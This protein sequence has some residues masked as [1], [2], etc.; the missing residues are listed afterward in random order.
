MSKKIHA[1]QCP[2]CSSTEQSE[3]KE[4]HYRCG[5]CGTEY[6]VENGST[7]IKHYHYYEPAPPERVS[8]VGAKQWAYAIFGCIAVTAGLIALPI[9]GKS[10]S[11]SPQSRTASDIT[12]DSEGR[13]RRISHKQSFY[14]GNAEHPNILA[15]LSEFHYQPNPF[16]LTFYDPD[17]GKII[18][19][20][21]FGGK[22]EKDNVSTSIRVKQFATGEIYLLAGKESIPFT[23]IYRLDTNTLGLQEMNEAFRKANPELS[24][25][26]ATVEPY[27]DD[28][29]FR[30]MTNSGKKLHYYPHSNR[31]FTEDGQ[32]DY[33]Y[34]KPPPVPADAPERT[35]LTFASRNGSSIAMEEGDQDYLFEY[36][37]KT[38]DGFP[39]AP[40]DFYWNQDANGKR[41]VWNDETRRDS[42]IIKWRDVTPGRDYYRPR[43]ECRSGRY[44]LIT[45]H[46]TV[47]KSS[48]VFLQM[49]DT[50]SGQPVWTQKLGAKEEIKSCRVGAKGEAYV[51][52]ST[53]GHRVSFKIASDGKILNGTHWIER[54][55]EATP[56]GVE[57]L[58]LFE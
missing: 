24:Q 36:I 11:P 10:R 4:N 44:A 56:E 38:P 8:P 43:L 46:E 35:V 26:I 39:F 7:Q 33:L 27:N 40:A 19:Q 21:A 9:I 50:S 23:D 6:F 20:A 25:G 53:D 54:L 13:L 5:N 45:F 41:I 22:Y 52:E 2:Q 29:S 32:R 18:G 14:F 1:V 37:Q 31:A 3:I 51:F 47:A 30:I 42:R 15:V 17:S 48:P 55:D 49:L 58:S 28:D 12:V 16:R 34:R 57:T